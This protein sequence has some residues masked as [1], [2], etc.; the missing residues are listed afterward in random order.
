METLK[1]TDYPNTSSGQELG[2]PGTQITLPPCTERIPSKSRADGSFINTYV[3][4]PLARV[5]GF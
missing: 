1:H 4:E 5:S 2:T 3:T